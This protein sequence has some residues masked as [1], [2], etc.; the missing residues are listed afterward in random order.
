MFN[1]GRYTYMYCELHTMTWI[2]ELTML[3]KRDFTKFISFWQNNSLN[4]V[5]LEQIMFSMIHFARLNPVY[6]IKIVLKWPNS[7]FFIRR[8]SICIEIENIS[9]YIIWGLFTAPEIHVVEKGSGK[10]EKL[11]TFELERSKWNL[12]FRVQVG[13]TEF[14][15]FKLRSELSNEM[16]FVMQTF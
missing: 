10:N 7:I 2:I 1:I 15:T 5:K 13:N 12:K 14:K 6:T 9:R 11:E 4:F 16:K 8:C 3:N